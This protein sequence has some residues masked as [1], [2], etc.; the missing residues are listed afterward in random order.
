MDGR[1]FKLE[2]S[3]S[4]YI[5]KN[6]QSNWDF[7]KGETKYGYNYFKEFILCF[8]LSIFYLLDQDHG[9]VIHAENGNTDQDLD[10]DLLT[11]EV[12]RKR[13]KRAEN[14]VRKDQDH[15]EEI[16][17]DLKTGTILFSLN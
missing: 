16:E 13:R 17:K 5:W 6:Q 11:E 3:Y 9:R 15:A 4:I 1:P 7:E 2:I 8:N 10:P 14:H 12:K